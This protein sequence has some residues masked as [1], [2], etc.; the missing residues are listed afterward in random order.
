MTVVELSDPDAYAHAIAKVLFTMDARALE[1]D[2][3]RRLLM[4]HADPLMSETG[5]A[6][7][8][9]MVDERV[10]DETQWS[11]MRANRQWSQWSPT[12]GWEPETWTA[13][14]TEGRAEPGW[15]MRNVTGTQTTHY[16]DAR[17]QRTASSEPTVT[18]GM[19]CPT[20]GSDVDHCYLTMIG[21]VV[22]P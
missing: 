13:V 5:V 21:T 7:L 9:H 18:I 15:A 19:R 6:D 16:V 1:A 12:A 10:P 8:R 2:D 4:A 17:Q 11:R 20:P 3:Y 14:V 22:V